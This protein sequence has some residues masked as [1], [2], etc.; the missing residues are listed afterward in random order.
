MEIEVIWNYFRFSMRE[1]IMVANK[2]TLVG[3]VTGV[4]FNPF[5]LFAKFKILP[6]FRGM[7]TG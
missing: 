4:N 6:A 7:N 2:Y 1:K 5:P 3:S